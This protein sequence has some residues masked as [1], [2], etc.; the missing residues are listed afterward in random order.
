LWSMFTVSLAAQLG[1]AP[2]TL[3]Y[4]QQFPNYFLLTNFL[5]IPLSGLVIY[6]AL[7]LLATAA[8]PSVFSI[9][10]WLL[11]WAL[12]ALNGLI[13]GIQNLPYS[14]WHVSFDISQTVVV[15]FAIFCLSAYYYNRR[16]APLFVGLTSI[17]MACLLSLYIEFQ[18]LT[19]AHLIVY[20]G[21]KGTHVGLIDRNKNTVYTTDS[22]EIQRIAKNYWQNSKLDA[23]RFVLKTDDVDRSFISFKGK[24]MMI[25]TDD[26]LKH[27]TTTQ[28]LELDYLVIGSRMKP[29]VE[30][31][32][33]CV[34]PKEIIIDKSV[35]RWYTDHI[36]SVCRS[37]GIR[38]YAIAE[39]GAFRLSMKD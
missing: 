36:C 29:R 3:Y 21:Q 13:V 31:I 30:Y 18:T 28:P 11:K 38:C 1:T 5:A 6:L 9:I 19:S 15:F 8:L 35:S 37:K 27:K 16:F 17:L 10:A 14:V 34:R 33:E 39:Q 32:L 26:F 4:F 22:V 23:P 2:F 7:A 20:A 12:L 24:R 25:L